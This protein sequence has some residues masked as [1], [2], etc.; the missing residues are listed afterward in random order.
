[1]HTVNFCIKQGKYLVVKH[2]D[3]HQQLLENYQGINYLMKKVYNRKITLKDEEVF[4][5]EKI[6]NTFN[7]INPTLF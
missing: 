1:M 5:L 2:P 7:P 4:V 6:N 3:K